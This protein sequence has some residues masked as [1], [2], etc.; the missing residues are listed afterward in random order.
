MLEETEVKLSY[1]FINGQL[2]YMLGRLLTL[3][4]AVVSEPKQNKAT[5]D[6]VNGMINEIRNTFWLKSKK[7]KTRQDLLSGDKE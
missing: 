1:D 7:Q 3:I 5:K 6:M 2:G 4:D